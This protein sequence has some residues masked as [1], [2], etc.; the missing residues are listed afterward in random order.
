M[1]GRS[2]KLIAA[3]KSTVIT[4]SLFDAI[5]V[6]DGEGD[7]SFPDP[8]CTNESD[9]FQISSEFNDLLNQLF[10]SEKGPW[11]RGRRFSEKGTMKT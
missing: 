11:C 2:W 4:K 7:R 8:P 10:T 9:R 1:S 5:I 3:N 6:E